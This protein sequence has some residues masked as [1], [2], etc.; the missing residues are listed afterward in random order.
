MANNE[1]IELEGSPENS[2]ANSVEKC[3]N[4]PLNI[5][6]FFTRSSNFRINLFAAYILCHMLFPANAD[7]KFTVVIKCASDLSAGNT[8][9]TCFNGIAKLRVVCKI[10]GWFFPEWENHDN[11][12][13]NW[14]SNLNCKWWVFLWGDVFNQALDYASFDEKVVIH[15]FHLKD[16]LYSLKFFGLKLNSDL[17]FELQMLEMN[18]FIVPTDSLLKIFPYISLRSE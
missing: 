18:I 4:K 15:F 8:A 17:F 13:L 9:L 16:R 14:T 7:I 6:T 12:C 5:A 2:P 1:S 3:L 11:A 10:S